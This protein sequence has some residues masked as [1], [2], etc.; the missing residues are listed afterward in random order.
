MDWYLLHFNIQFSAENGATTQFE[1]SAE[2]GATTQ[3]ESQ[4][5]M[6]CNVF[7][8]S[9]YGV[10]LLDANGGMKNGR[11]SASFTCEKRL[12]CLN[13]SHVCPEPVLAKRSFRV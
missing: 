8:R 5:Y 13:F 6:T 1:I 4:R 2:N 3:L 12:S 7:C 10:K 11:P 9:R